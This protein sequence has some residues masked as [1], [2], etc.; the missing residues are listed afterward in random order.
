MP[1]PLLQQ[2][3]QAKA[4][5]RESLRQMALKKLHEAFRE[6]LADQAV[7]VY[8][9]ILKPGKFRLESDI[10]IAL[11]RPSAK[12]SLYALQSLLTE[13]TGYQVDICMLQETRLREAIM[14]RGQRWTALD[15]ERLETLV[16]HAEELAACQPTR[17]EAFI[18]EVQINIEEA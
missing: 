1:L 8:G 13:A 7:W 12:D 15:V 9:S 14:L 16:Q 6:H 4:I 2:R 10:D 5:E 3:D 18:R 11:E 17:I